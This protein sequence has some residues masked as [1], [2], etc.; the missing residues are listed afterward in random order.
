MPRAHGEGEPYPAP[1]RVVTR[2]QPRR[3]RLGVDWCWL[4]LAVLL[5]LDLGVAS[6]LLLRGAR[7]RVTGWLAVGG[8]HTVPSGGES[9]QS[10]TASRLVGTNDI[11][12]RS[13][14]VRGEATPTWRLINGGPRSRDPQGQARLDGDLADELNSDM[15]NQP[16]NNRPRRRHAPVDVNGPYA[17]AH[18]QDTKARA[19][20]NFP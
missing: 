20:D 7:R 4:P 18:E 6:G 2:C 5:V 17:A 19:P 16:S 10:S 8:G 9:A 15:S 14:S 1:G 13:R 12:L 3:R 11:S